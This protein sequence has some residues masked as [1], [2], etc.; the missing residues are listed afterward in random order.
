MRNLGE[1]IATHRKEKKMTQTALAEALHPYGFYLKPNSISSW[2]ANNSVPNAVQLLALCEIF[3]IYDIYTEFIGSNP[4]NPFRNLNHE[5]VEKAKDYIQ[6][7]EKSGDYENADNIIPI[8][9]VRERKVFYLPVS[10]GTGSFLDGE[11]YE[12]YSSTDIPETSD[13]GVHVQGDSMEP[14]Y[15]DEQLVWIQQ[16]EQL[17]SGEIGIFY[18]DGNAYIKKLLNN[19]KGT[20]LISLNKKYDPIPVTD[21]SSFKIFGRV[22][23]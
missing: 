12:M 13:F 18:L 17:R 19:K 6:L 20:F 2:E 9:V 14:R 16:T 4:T 8:S 10:A 1:I 5:G 15:H 7:L 21:N 11:D 23:N 3:G 22:L